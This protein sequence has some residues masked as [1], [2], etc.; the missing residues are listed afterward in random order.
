MYVYAGVPPVTVV[1]IAPSN[2]V[3][4]EAL[5]T[6]APNKIADGFVKL[7]LEVTLQPFASVKV[8]E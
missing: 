1:D 7:K 5:V 4:Q 6:V 8:K 3:L 2:A